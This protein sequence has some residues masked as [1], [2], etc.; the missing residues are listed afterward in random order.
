M[1]KIKFIFLVIFSTIILAIILNMKSTILNKNATIMQVTENADVEY[2]GLTIIA[3]KLVPNKTDSSSI[4]A[5]TAYLQELI[6]N[7]SAAGGGIVHIPA[8][9]YYFASAG[10]NPRKVEEHVI[11]CK[12]NVIL[13]GEGINENNGTVLKPYG[14]VTLSQ[15]GLDMFYFN[16][17][18][19]SNFQTV[20][21]L[22]NADFRNFVIDGKE[23]KENGYNSSG[24]GFMINLF[25]DCD[26]ENVVVKNTY[27]TGFGMDCPINSTIKNCKAENCGRGV[28]SDDSPG[29]SGFGIGTGYSDD[30]SIIIS[31]CKADGNGKFGFFFEHQ[32]RFTHNY[33][34][35]ASKGFVVSNCTAGSN[36]YDFGGLRAN[37]VTFENCTSTSSNSA[38]NTSG[39]D[40]VTPINF[41]D[42]SRR[43]HIVNCKVDKT[44]TDVA[45]STIYYY[46]PVYWAL[47]NGIATGSSSTKFEP[48]EICTRAQ[49]I[50]LLYRMAERTKEGVY[51][52]RSEL[53]YKDV[54]VN[55]VAWG[56][57]VEWAKNEGITDS[58]ED[59][60]FYPDNGCTRAE[61]I[62][63]LWK[64][65]G[66]PIVD[67]KHNFSDI[68]AGTEYEKAVN[69]GL[70]KGIVLGTDYG[71]FSPNEVCKRGQIITF[72]YRYS[73]ANNDFNI[74]YNLNGGKVSTANPIS[75]KSGT[76]TVTL[77]NPTK[78]GYTF[79]G[80][81]GSNSAK[82]QKV[83][84]INKSDAG[85]KAYTANW[86]ANNYTVSFNANGGTG[87]MED[88]YFKYDDVPQKLLTNDFKRRGYNFKGWNTNSGGTG[89]FYTDAAFV[90]NLTETNGKTITLYAQWAHEEHIP[91]V[92]K[93]VEPTCTQ[94]GLTEGK[95]CEICNLVITEQETI[96]ALGHNY[97]DE[98]TLP[99]CTE[100]GYTTHRC[101]RCGDSYVDTYTNAL[102][103]SFTNYVSNN[104]ATCTADGTKTAKCDRCNETKTITDAGS[105]RGHVEVK[106]VG[107]EPTCTETGLTEGKHCSVC[108]EVLIE[109][110]TIAA[111]GH[112]Y[113]NGI[114]T[115]CGAELTI[116][117]TSD[118]YSVDDLYITKI[119][120]QKTVKE[121]KD[122]IE[123]NATQISIYNK[124][125]ELLKDSDIIA[126]GM[127]VEVKL[128][129]QTKIFKLS[130]IG[131]VN[132][133]GKIKLSDMSIV[134]RYRLN[135]QTLE[136]EYLLAADVNEDG[137]V[138]FKDLVKINKFRLHKITEL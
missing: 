109:Q 129:K 108:Q 119:Q 90:R 30:E 134:N 35:T 47:N 120:N 132:G 68:E 23:V 58:N 41:Q 101:T 81:T 116:E 11:K 91:V 19:D 34:A 57:E 6:D 36:M 50:I 76:N 62:T 95:H 39:L 52:Y 137:K 89:I 25:K 104:D 111:L 94:T 59:T 97:G 96:P 1:R 87:T 78:T 125:Q 48:E 46:E 124:N 102:G 75:Y 65:S 110:K 54:N 64:Y 79:S 22:E 14:T 127:Q 85:N 88:E 49:A 10:A 28:T 53:I 73:K 83:V 51:S 63:F 29:G 55:N 15:G 56:E 74:T 18:A 12:N 106:D 77:N 114:C 123:T 26:W 126:T 17:Y 71:K 4:K 128:G 138:D 133:D 66:S 131:D 135:K 98:I 27:A 113:E 20:T 86:T 45:D 69:W 31:N 32:G 44:F 105:K 8:G 43:T 13:E 67:T 72:L 118:E 37:D 121:F 93:A 38:Q 33:N 115:N 117:I 7:V 130:V 80:W 82:P 99:T 61:F 60:Y 9:T 136:G 103:H 40:F 5:N 2:Q 21:Y 70:S 42:R 112:N 92:D 16:D 122:N 107:K 24:K 84:V 100:K 3:E